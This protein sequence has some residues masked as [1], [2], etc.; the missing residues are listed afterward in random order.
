MERAKGRALLGFMDEKDALGFLKTHCEFEGKTDDELLKEWKSAKTVVG[1]LAK[2]DLSPE[3]LGLDA[4]HKNYLDRLTKAPQFLEAVGQSA[5]SFKLVEIDKL[6]CFQKFVDIEYKGKKPEGKEFT[7]MTKLIEFCLPTEPASRTVGMS[8]SDA[9][10][11]FTLFSQGQDHRI[12]APYDSVDPMSKRRM[13]GFITG[14]GSRLILVVKFKDR[15]FLK[16]GYHRVYEL[17]KN[18]VKYLPCILLEGRDFVDTGAAKL[19]FFPQNLLM[20]DRPPQLIHFFSDQISPVVQLR[21]MT[22]V[23][24]IKAEEFP[25]FAEAD[26]PPTKEGMP[27][28]PKIESVKI[29][30]TEYE[31]FE[32][33]K[34]G[35]NIYRLNDGTLLKLRQVLLTLKLDPSNQSMMPNISNL[36][37]G[38]MP[39]PSLKGEPSPQQYSPEELSNSIVERNMKY[40]TLLET[41]SEYKTKSG[42][43]LMLRL[44]E[45][46]VSR[47]NKFDSTGYPVYLVNTQLQI[48]VEQQAGQA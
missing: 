2:T 32:I 39:A 34:E 46:V 13:H 6:V 8:Y 35:W 47:T 40:E 48:Q 4:A 41:P 12:I 28:G 31:D 15:F 45:V 7:D 30:G 36:L 38:V 26:L 22:K 42:L 1:S 19:G 16:N 17:K 3:I 21:S 44:S 14:W 37:M 27:V 29:P 24:R 5:W 25:V 18:H 9:E 23:I 20:S 11:S 10:K 33:E 43:N